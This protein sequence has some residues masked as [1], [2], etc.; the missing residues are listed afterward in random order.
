MFEYICK[1]NLLHDS[2]VQK[3]YA[4]ANKHHESLSFLL[5][6]I[7]C[8]DTYS[9]NNKNLSHFQS[10]LNISEYVT[11]MAPLLKVYKILTPVKIKLANKYHETLSFLLSY[12]TCTDTYSV[13]NK[14]LF[15][16]QS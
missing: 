15:P 14:N 9:V 10:G 5:S 4:L 7:T 11:K 1:K 8:T 16:F 12:S 6:Y 2:H 13:N 3:K